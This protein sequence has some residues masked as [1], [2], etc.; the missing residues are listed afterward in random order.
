MRTI[1]FICPSASIFP[2]GAYEGRLV[3]R[4]IQSISK[5]V[6][7]K[8]G[9]TPYNVSLTECEWR[10]IARKT[11]TQKATAARETTAPAADI[12]R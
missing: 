12:G 7:A 10:S 1:G 5:N 2:R 8:N 9:N 6:Q 11:L 3:F 4:A